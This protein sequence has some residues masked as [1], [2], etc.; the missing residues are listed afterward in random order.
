MAKVTTSAL[1]VEHG[2]ID[3]ID[4]PR[5]VFRQ[6]HGLPDPAQETVSH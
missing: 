2:G 4:C 6:V 5:V 3:G 1:L